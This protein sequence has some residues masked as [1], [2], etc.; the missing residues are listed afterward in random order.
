MKMSRR[1]TYAASLILSTALLTSSAYACG[2]GG[3]SGLSIAVE[4]GIAAKLSK[5]AELAKA[6]AVAQAQATSKSR[7]ATTPNTGSDLKIEEYNDG[8]SGRD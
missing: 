1:M 7:S 8:A 6:A 4:K 3:D 2:C 5:G